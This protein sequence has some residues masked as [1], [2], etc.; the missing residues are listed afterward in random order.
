MAKKGGKKGN[1]MVVSKVK[2]ANH[3]KNRKKSSS[4]KRQQ[5]TSKT[6][7][8]DQSDK[9]QGKNKDSK[10]QQ[11][12]AR[13]GM[14]KVEI[15]KLGKKKKQP[16]KP[17]VQPNGIVE[18]DF[19]ADEMLDMMDEEDIEIF[20]NKANKNNKRPAAN[21]DIDVAKKS[22]RVDVEDEYD[23][24]LFNQNKDKKN[25][26]PLL[27]IK[28]RQGIVERSVEID[29]LSENSESELEAEEEEKEPLSMAEIFAKRKAKVEELKAAIGCA[30]SS[31]TENPEERMEN[32]SAILKLFKGL[33][34]DV[35]I[36]G[37]K[38][39]S[40]SLVNLFRDLAPTYEIK[41]TNKAGDKL[42]KATRVVYAVEGRLLK[43]YQMFLKKLEGLFSIAVIQLVFY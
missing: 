5:I 23:D 16:P 9:P 29:E 10:A 24:E 7:K 1:S 18:E 25:T 8:N 22:R 31:I 37:F 28:T 43:Y 33:T 17:V 21:G 4:D 32:I 15:P 14:K 41:N 35:Y 26:R 19:E 6:K 11:K 3:M 30:S 27:P 13:N 2:R 39:I 42:K 34:A 36:T 40:A 20:R 38:L 12:P